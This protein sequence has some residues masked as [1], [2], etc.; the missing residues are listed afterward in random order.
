[1]LTACVFV[2]RE[3]VSS[4]TLCVR[5]ICSW[6][7]LFMIRGV[8]EPRFDCISD[9]LCNLDDCVSAFSECFVENNYVFMY[10]YKL[11]LET[12]TENQCSWG[13]SN[14]TWHDTKCVSLFICV[15]KKW[16]TSNEHK[17][18]EVFLRPCYERSS[19]GCRT[20]RTDTKRC[21]GV[22]ERMS[23]AENSSSVVL[24][25]I[26]LSRKRVIGNDTY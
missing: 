3:T 5:K 11:K 7:E 8:R 2:T 23:E 26:L 13:P 6:T 22:I 19:K 9:T 20:G 18:N 10:V 1:M 17:A 12:M 25:C 15:N 4:E 16:A 14:A 24:G 21:I